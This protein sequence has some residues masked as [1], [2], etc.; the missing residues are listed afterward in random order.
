[1]D[2]ETL[3]TVKAFVVDDDEA[4]RDSLKVLLEIHGMEVEDYASTGSFAHHYRRPRRGVLILD[5]HLPSRTGLD[6]L[7]SPAGR[8]LGIPVILITGRGDNDIE[9]RARAAGAAAYLQKPIGEKILLATV[10][11][12]VDAA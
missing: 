8:D 12:V 3:P 6:F 4:V 5:Q 10:S 7:N 9:A 2:S 1:M 11:R